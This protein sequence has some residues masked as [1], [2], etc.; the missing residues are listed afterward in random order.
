MTVPK[1]RFKTKQR[2]SCQSEKKDD[3]L[4]AQPNIDVK[5]RAEK[6]LAGLFAPP[7]FDSK[8]V[9]NAMTKNPI[10]K[11]I[12]PFGTSMLDLS[13]RAMTAKTKMLDGLG[14]AADTEDLK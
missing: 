14:D 6:S 5:S 2:S 9:P 3:P 12:V 11:G 4:Q 10:N 13:I 1:M 7:Q 8:V